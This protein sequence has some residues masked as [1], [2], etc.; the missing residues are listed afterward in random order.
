M[1][2]LSRYF[3]RSALLC[4]AVGFTIGGLILS[5]KAGAVDAGLWAW[6]PEHIALLLYGWLIQLSLGVGYWI[7]PRVNVAERGR[8]GWAWASFVV[9]QTGIGLVLLSMLRLWI[10]A[11]VGLFPLAV[12]WQAT[13]VLLFAI[14]AWPRIHAAIVRAAAEGT[15]QP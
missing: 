7:L 15:A 1:P 11:M 5:A 2:L 12:I 13:G 3:V 4:L 14:H 8:R 10:P 6:L 9:S